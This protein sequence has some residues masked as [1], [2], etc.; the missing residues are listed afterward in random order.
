MT[1]NELSGKVALVTGASR[2]LG[3]SIARSLGT[4]GAKVAVNTF[5]SPDK[6]KAVADAIRTDGGEA[7]GFK[8][9]VR[10][11]AE[12]EAM[13]TAIKER[14]GPVEILVCNATGPQPFVTLED[15]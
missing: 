2:G 1:N 12:V 13:V 4:R 11:E 14:F 15:L 5:G 9:D 6:A 7:E 10:D 3:A 8:A